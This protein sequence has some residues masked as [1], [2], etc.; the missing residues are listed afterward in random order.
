MKGILLRVGCDQTKTGGSWNAPVNPVSWQYAYVPI[1]ED[2]AKHNHFS[3]CPTYA[4]FEPSIR[5]LGTRLPPALL[6]QAK[7]HLDPDF[8]SLT[9]GQPFKKD[10]GKLSSRGQIINQLSIGDFIAFYSAFRPTQVGY[11]YPLAY[12]LF[13]IFYIHR[14]TYVKDLSE[15]ERSQF[16]HGRRANADN[17]LVV[18]GAPHNSGRFEQAI[19]IGEYR[20]GAYRVGQELL[21]TWG[22]LTVKDG[23][24]QRS[25]RPP[26]FE[27]PAKFLDWLGQQSESL[28]LV[29]QN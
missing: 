13:G 4:M 20:R 27:N 14:K 6:P 8:A 2:E 22:G 3:P 21:A 15:K 16:A 7:V 28:R 23:Y 18:W 19:P 11:K 25:A 17:D 10:R 24:I 5:S 1:P 26:F 12:C 29:W 9:F